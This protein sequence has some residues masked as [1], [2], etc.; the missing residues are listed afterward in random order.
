MAQN[1]SNVIPDQL[2]V[3]EGGKQLVPPPS[4]GDSG[5]VLGVL[6]S[7]GDIG[8]TEDR[9]GMAQQQADWAE[10]D[11]SKVTYIANKPTIPTVD[12]TYNASS[13]NAQSGVAV[14][15]AI[16]GVNAVPA[17]TSSDSGK[18]LKVDAQGAPVWDDAGGAFEIIEWNSVTYN[19]VKAAYDA[20]KQPVIL[21]K[22][23]FSDQPLYGYLVSREMDPYVPTRVLRFRFLSLKSINAYFTSDQSAT[24]V[25]Y[26]VPNS[27]QKFSAEAKVAAKFTT[28]SSVTLTQDGVNQ[29]KISVANPLPASTSSEEGS[30]LTVNSSG[31]A[32]WATPSTVTVDQTYD[33]SSSNAQSGTAVAGAIA[34]VNQVP[35]STSVDA[36]KVLTVNSSGTPEWATA[37]GGGGGTT[38]GSD[39]KTVLHAST[40]VAKSL[41]QTSSGGA[42]PGETCFITSD[43]VSGTVAAIKVPRARYQFVSSASGLY[44]TTAYIDLY[45][46]GT[47]IARLSSAKAKYYN[48]YYY[49]S[50]P[51]FWYIPST[52]LA[53]LGTG[54]R[55][56][57]VLSYHNSG[58]YSNP[59][60][61][62]SAQFFPYS[63]TDRYIAP[64]CTFSGAL[65]PSSANMPSVSLQIDTDKGVYERETVDNYGSP[66]YKLTINNTRHAYD[67]DNYQEPADLSVDRMEITIPLM[68]DQF[69]DGGNG[70]QKR[71]PV[72]RDFQKYGGQ[73]HGMQDP[74]FNFIEDP[75]GGD[76]FVV[77]IE[78]PATSTASGDHVAFCYFTLCETVEDWEAET[79]THYYHNFVLPGI[80]RSNYGGKFMADG[81][82]TIS[83]S[84]SNGMFSS[85]L[86]SGPD[87]VAMES[88][89]TITPSYGV[90]GWN[91]CV[92]KI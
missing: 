89:V 81:I 58:S 24:T 82:I 70:Y 48:N 46:S 85:Q 43:D 29:I 44:D 83:G 66:S 36:D 13:S 69:S 54:E 88:G 27:G 42:Y 12:Q 55:Y 76:V 71:F 53:A 91:C 87:I 80:Y 86:Y 5:K 19:L 20:G 10:A 51:E 63:D 3:V 28:D 31:N 25:Q 1:P 35:S 41:Y 72:A 67:W 62:G 50:F 57:L 59:S 26:I 47:F 56:S 18:V 9:E 74:I 8:W 40:P 79:I 16:A 34:G 77:H 49:L 4:S 38:V 37:Q 23:T 39:L 92:S 33:S 65:K 61:G 90:D 84:H 2:I 60:T 11:P 7:N 15:G 14:A 75:K 32:A 64:D 6:N 78:A 22:T 52:P 30:V 73:N 68:D 17:S 45:K 21:D